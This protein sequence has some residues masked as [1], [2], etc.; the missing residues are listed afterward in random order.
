[1]SKTGRLPAGRAAG[2]VTAQVIGAVL[3]EGAHIVK[4][5][6]AVI[7]PWIAWPIVLV[8][9][10]AQ[11]LLWRGW[12]S[13]V[14]IVI[15]GTGLAA[16]NLHLTH[17]R[18]TILGRYAAAGTMMLIAGWVAWVAVA[19]LGLHGPLQA[20]GMG[21]FVLCLAWTMWLKIRPESE[22]AGGLE[23]LFGRT[24][25]RAGQQPLKVS[26]VQVEDHA[27]T[28]E[29]KLPPGV[30]AKDLEKTPRYIEGA[31]GLPPGSLQITAHDEHAGKVKV[32]LS[33]P[34]LIRKPQPWP[35]PSMPGASIAQPICPSVYQ[36]G[37]PL[38]YKVTNHHL[39]LAGTTGAGKSR[40]WGWSEVGETVT[41]RDAGVLGIDLTKGF[42][43]VG[44]LMPALHRCETTV[45]GATQLL[46]AIHRMIRPRT[47]WLAD[48]GLGEWREGC[49]LIH[50]T[51]WLEEA[52]EVF[53]E[54]DNAGLLE[55]WVQ[56]VRTSRSA[57]IRWLVSM[58]RPDWTQ[59]PTLARGQMAHCCFGLGQDSDDKF[60]LSSYQFDHCEPRPSA[61]ADTYPGM[62]YLDHGQIKPERKVMSLRTWYWGDNNDLITE[63]CERYTAAS[64][65]ADKL[66]MDILGPIR[67][68][69]PRPQ[70][71]QQQ[72][73]TTTLTMPA[74]PADP[75]DA[76]VV[77]TDPATRLT[78]MMAA[79]PQHGLHAVEDDEPAEG[80]IEM[81]AD[82]TRAEALA[83]PIDPA[84]G[85]RITFTA[86]TSPLARLG[87]EEADLALRQQINA[88]LAGGK[89]DFTVADMAEVLEI[90]GRKRPWIYNR[91]AV[92]E[93][94]G[95]L[96]KSGF[97]VG[98][99]IHQP[100]QVNAA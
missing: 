92:L 58:Q 70:Q 73:D 99:T 81:T 62:H 91:V 40:G 11:W 80:E 2:M 98:W 61:W 21:G 53:E 77:L 27:V 24:A 26:S 54:L 87:P 67:V 15:A 39:R 66:S 8:L 36:D 32:S 78:A 43:T 94:E 28:G 17:Q 88:W 85:P 51:C 22:T 50:W 25:I 76:A 42:Q 64:R 65:P 6:G 71:P 44:P 46:D 7:S 47:D 38:A 37:K 30:I 72:R 63:H 74:P 33:N 1:M 31:A 82:M 20:W 4:R 90:T 34:L 48:R 95:V 14:F 35:G 16:L 57:G 3:A 60:G 56:D 52:P 49:G 5:T 19:G 55:Q 12:L 97:G 23:D 45:G 59:M 93:G 29:L 69:N 75:D 83:L 96:R 84:Q 18:K 100:A 89:T 13:A 10:L 9:G 41:R 86:P 79:A 68:P